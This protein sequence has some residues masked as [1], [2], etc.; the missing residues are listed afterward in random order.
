MYQNTSFSNKWFYAFVVN[1]RFS[2]GS[3]TEIT[4][5]TDVWQTWQFEL[6]FMPSFI[7]RE[8]INPVDD[9]PRCKSNT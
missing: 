1:M 7:E 2:S 3:M 6:H 8:M 4:I 5:V 9:V